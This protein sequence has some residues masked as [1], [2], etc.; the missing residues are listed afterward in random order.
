MKKT[1]LRITMGVILVVACVS[2]GYTQQDESAKLE[3]D[4][5]ELVNKYRQ[6]KKLVALKTNDFVR[7]E[8]MNHTMRMATGAVPL[9]HQD[10]DDRF[11]RI[12]A[13]FSITDGAENVAYGPNSAYKIVE[14]WLSSEDHKEN[15][16]G[17]YNFTGIG[18]VATGT[19][20]YYVTM[21]YIKSPERPK[22]V[23][24]EFKQELFGYVNKHRKDCKMA[25]LEMNQQIC[26]EAL[27]YTESM[28]FGKVPIGPPSFDNP[29]RQLVSKMGARE[30]VE[31][32][33][34]QLSTSR[35]V[36]DS[37]MNS[38]LQRKIVEGSYNLTG[39][40]VVQSHDGRVFVTQIFMSKK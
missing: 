34:Y 2:Q 3:S 8:A 39:I 27:K 19:G 21:I 31:L 12:G 24:E 9:S 32:V 5:L 36:F 29:L 30:M 26:D 20:A 7:A 22:I 18:V 38:T 33:S 35:E 1:L 23:V 11:G 10:F 4:I 14:N 17:D 25:P 15:M 13:K 37:W 40:G 16:E 6:S 28:A